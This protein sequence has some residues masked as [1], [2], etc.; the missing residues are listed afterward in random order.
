M[1]ITLIGSIKFAPQMVEVFARLKKM[2]HEPQMLEGMFGLADG[3][4]TEL[5]KDISIDHGVTKRKYDLFRKWH[6]LIK[7]GEAV[8]VCNF[9]KKGIANYI[10]GNT[11]IEMGFAHVNDKQVF[12]LNPVPEGVPYT[13]EIRGLVD[14]VIGGDLGR[15]GKGRDI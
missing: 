15:L 3:T 1:R 13:D 2:G 11:L 4:A 7:S 10:G 6:D 8:L 14:D 12:L 5:I 9:D